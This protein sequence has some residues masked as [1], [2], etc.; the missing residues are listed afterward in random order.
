MGHVSNKEVPTPKSN[1]GVLLFFFCGNQFDLT[2]TDRELEDFLSF[3]E[4]QTAGTYAV[5][6]PQL[7]NAAADFSG[8]Q[9]Q[10]HSGSPSNSEGSESMGVDAPG[11]STAQ[12]WKSA[13][14]GSTASLCGAAAAAGTGGSGDTDSS[15]G[16]DVAAMTGVSTPILPDDLPCMM[17]D[18]PTAPLPMEIKVEPQDEQVSMIPAPSSAAPVMPSISAAGP[19]PAAAAAAMYLPAPEASMSLL[20]PQPDNLYLGAGGQGAV[21]LQSSV[22]LPASALGLHP[23]WAAGAAAPQLLFIQGNTAAALAGQ[24]QQQQQQLMLRQGST[25]NTSDGGP[26]MSPTASQREAAGSNRQHNGSKATSSSIHRGSASYDACGKLQISHSTVEKQRRDR[27]NSLID[28]LSDIVPPADPKYGNDATSVRRPKHVVLSDTINLLRAMQTKLQ[29]EEAEICTLKQQAAAVAA[30]A[31]Q[32]QQQQQQPGHAP[33]MAAALGAAVAA[34]AA[35]AAATMMA[36]G[37]GATGL[38]TAESPDMNG[39]PSLPQPPEGNISSTG[40]AALSVVA[41]EHELPAVGDVGP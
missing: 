32:Q 33:L 31:A 16:C 9:L 25:T 34:P 8:L 19:P 17:D 40:R 29:L 13:C 21:S 27:L 12:A 37:P 22:S 11:Q 1:Q 26:L 4:H 28:E 36:A 5:S 24:Q 15:K 10:P 41:A 6:A 30:L 7:P 3:M 2:L 20:P 38:I 14:P 35:P 39:L 18:P 23:Q